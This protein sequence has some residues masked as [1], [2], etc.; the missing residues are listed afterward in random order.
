MAEYLLSEFYG[1]QEECAQKEI[2]EEVDNIDL[3]N[4]V[5]INQITEENIC[6]DDEKKKRPE[7]QSQAG[8][9]K[10]KTEEVDL[11]NELLQLILKNLETKDVITVGQTCRRWFSVGGRVWQR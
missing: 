1:F 10:L 8:S 9:K 11:P 7:Y 5:E 6:G 2:L 3:K 4:E